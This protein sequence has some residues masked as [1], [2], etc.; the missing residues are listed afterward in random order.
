VSIRK[1]KLGMSCVQRWEQQCLKW[2]FDKIDGK[3]YA[4]QKYLDD[5]AVRY[6]DVFISDLPGVNLAY[7]NVNQFQLR[8]NQGK[9]WVNDTPLIFYHFS[10]LK[11]IRSGVYDPQWNQYGVRPNDVLR[12]HIYRPYLMALRRQERRLGIR[13]ETQSVRY[14]QAIRSP[15]GRFKTIRRVIRGQYLLS[16]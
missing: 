1:D 9:V 13:T 8:W 5:W 4:D 14:G 6:P 11:K 3:R 2:C 12:N 10:G 16:R 7:W 15:I